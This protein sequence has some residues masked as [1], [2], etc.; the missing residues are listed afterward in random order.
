M[1]IEAPV[2]GQSRN[3]HL[4]LVRTDRHCY[5]DETT[6]ELTTNQ[7]S[8]LG[9]KPGRPH[10]TR[11][12]SLCCLRA[13]SDRCLCTHHQYFSL[14]LLSR[15]FFGL[16]NKNLRVKLQ[17][18]VSPF[19]QCIRKVS[20]HPSASRMLEGTTVTSREVLNLGP[21]FRSTGSRMGRICLS[22]RVLEK[23]MWMTFHP[24]LEPLV[25]STDY[26]GHRT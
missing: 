24:H 6:F 14:P 13:L 11:P 10:L 12:A 8:Y 26:D 4:R 9:S 25:R 5:G 1:A 2:H 7:I 19:P 16:E 20:W 15:E 21:C 22:V 23:L 18:L 17:T 3:S